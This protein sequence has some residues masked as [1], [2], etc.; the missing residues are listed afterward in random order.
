MYRTNRVDFAIRLLL[1]V[2]C[3]LVTAGCGPNKQLLNGKWSRG[4]ETKLGSA[5]GEPLISMSKRDMTLYPDGSCT[6]EDGNFSTTGTWVFNGSTLTLTL[7]PNPPQI[8][9]IIKIDEAHLT[10]KETRSESVEE[11]ARINNGF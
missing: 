1:G 8:F 5:P 7:R 4:F 10:L 11:W 3:L 9:K 6:L 2:A